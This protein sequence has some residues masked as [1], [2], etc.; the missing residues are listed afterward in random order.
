MSVVDFETR[1][2]SRCVIEID[3]I[4]KFIGIRIKLRISIDD[5]K[6]MKRK[7]YVTK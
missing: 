6:L 3:M 2:Q 1:I 4:D 7:R 5:G